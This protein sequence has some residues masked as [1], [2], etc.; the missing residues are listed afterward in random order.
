M[1]IFAQNFLLAL[2]ATIALNPVM[3]VATILAGI[4]LD[5]LDIHKYMD[6]IY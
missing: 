2:A 6:V 4:K 5:S 1:R 3:E